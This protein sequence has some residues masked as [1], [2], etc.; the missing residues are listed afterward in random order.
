MLDIKFVREN[1]ELVKKG[2]H[3]KN[4]NIDVDRLLDIDRDRRSILK[5]LEE[6]RAKQ[7]R[8]N[9]VV[10]RSNFNDKA[11]AISEMKKISD[12][13]KDLEA[14]L[15][16][17]DE[18]YSS[19]ML[20]LPQPALPDV[21]VGGDESYN[22]E[23]KKVG[24]VRKFDF[25][26]KD[27]VT[28]GKNL[29]I[30]DIERAVKISGARNYILKGQGALL[31]EA[32]MTLAR[33]M[34]VSRGFQYMHIP[35][36]VR[37]DAMVGTGYFPF[38]KEDA[39][40]VEKDEKFLIGTAEVVLTSYHGDEIL[41]EALLPIKICSR[42][43]SFRREAGAYGKDT[44]GVY[45]VHQFTKIEQVILCKNNPEESAKY[46]REIL[47]NAEELVSKLGLPYR[48]LELCTG[49]MGAGQIKKHDIETWMPSRGGYGETHSCSSFH[50][51]QARRL[52][53]KYKDKEGNKNFVH[54]LNNTMVASPRI[55]IAIME[56]YQREDGSI[57]IP[58][59]LRPYMG[60]LSEI[61]K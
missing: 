20:Y 56:N 6:L 49:D 1:A 61:T 21:P 8:A 40:E 45:R 34:L 33:D 50:E 43:E 14:S 28:L 16:S 13:V 11:K 57:E 19:L 10:S 47:N 41:D 36:L 5:D 55:L 22:V 48:V 51:F 54:T 25:T 44:A 58:L 9:Q 12:R 4:M 37:Q 2:C 39:Y 46:H 15:K 26:P 59:V 18:E 29:D 27:H 17:I 35:Q 7:N 42:S 32:V 3:D 60:G 24:E 38:G 53:I 31:M 30:L 52:N 23:I